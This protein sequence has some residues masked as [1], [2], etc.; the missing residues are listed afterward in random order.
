MRASA[1][2]ERPPLASYLT[3]RCQ[4]G[5]GWFQ[6]AR[7]ETLGKSGIDR[8]QQF[9]GRGNAILTSPQLRQAD[10][11]SQFPGKRLLPAGPVERA[12]KMVLSGGEIGWIM[13]RE[14]HAFDAQH[15]GHAPEGFGLLRIAE[16]SV[17]FGQTLLDTT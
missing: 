9:A 13:L 12:P 5:S 7:R 1:G 17:D 6:V 11:G 3:Q 8:T 10:R 4:Q 15:L 14:D 16:R 2:V